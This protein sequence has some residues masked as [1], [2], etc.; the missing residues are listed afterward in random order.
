MALTDIEAVRLK[1][2]DKSEI[3]RE[4]ARGNGSTLTYKLGKRNILTSPAI[5]I[6]VNSAVMVEG[7]DFTVNHS[8]GV[9]DF[10]TA[11]ANDV[12]II[13]LYYWA[14]FTDDE[15][16]HF[17]T[18][19][20]SNITFAASQLLYALAAD[21]AKIAMRETLSGGGGMGST[22]R[23]TSL[24]AQELRETAKALQT[25][26]R[27]EEGGSSFPHQELTEVPW[28]EHMYD[29]MLEQELFRDS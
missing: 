6:W 9:V 18:S 14:V 22:T 17:L 29:R 1:T 10:T 4:V 3:T 19:A 2:G 12:E 11:P 15:V 8:H 27:E 23:D 21:A 7:V 13:F 20:G 5:T 25:I 24:T 26:Y 16:Q 28:T